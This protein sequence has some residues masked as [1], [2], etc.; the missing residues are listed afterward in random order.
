M[1]DIVV[2]KTGA[3]TFARRSTGVSPES[4]HVRVTCEAC[5]TSERIGLPDSE[6]WEARIVAMGQTLAT[7]SCCNAAIVAEV[8]GY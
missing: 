5:G 8:C 2:T 6:E 1:A 4:Q 7:T 3:G